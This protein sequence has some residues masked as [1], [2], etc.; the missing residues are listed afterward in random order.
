M[1]A[2]KSYKVDR[3]IDGRNELDIFFDRDKK[4]FFASIGMERVTH[5][6]I[7]EA[8]KLARELLKKAC[9]PSR[10]CS[11]THARSLTRSS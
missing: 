5:T 7:N 9:S 11:T 8:K 10:L 1:K 3:V 6:D 4:E 2:L